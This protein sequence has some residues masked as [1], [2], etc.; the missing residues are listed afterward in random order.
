M[1]INHTPRW[2]NIP[3]G[4]RRRKLLF[5]FFCLKLTEVASNCQNITFWRIMAFPSFSIDEIPV[6]TTIITAIQA[7]DNYVL[8]HPDS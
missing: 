8:I 5:G 3:V 2:P 4:A 1:P 6:N 7:E